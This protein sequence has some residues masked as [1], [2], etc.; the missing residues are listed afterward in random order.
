MDFKLVSPGELHLKALGTGA[1]RLKCI[2]SRFV[3]VRSSANPR[4]AQ[5]CSCNRITR[6]VRWCL[7]SDEGLWVTLHRLHSR[8]EQREQCL[9]CR[10]VTSTAFRV[11]A[12]RPFQHIIYSPFTILKHTLVNVLVPHLP[13][14]LSGITRDAWHHLD[15]LM[16]QFILSIVNCCESPGLG[17]IHGC[18]SIEGKK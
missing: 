5:Y 18:H 2:R 12:V 6:I 4:I 11:N 1:W 14:P 10:R 16:Y 13:L 8:Y 15:G 17:I 9:I 7:V 3:G